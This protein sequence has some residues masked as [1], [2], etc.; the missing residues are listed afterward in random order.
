MLEQDRRLVQ[1]VIRATV[2]NPDLSLLSFPILVPL[3]VNLVSNSR[4]LGAWGTL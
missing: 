1:V 3:R 4:S 2:S